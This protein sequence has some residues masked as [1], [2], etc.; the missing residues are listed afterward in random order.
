[1]QLSAVHHGQTVTSGA[2]PARG[3][4]LLAAVAGLQ[5]PLMTWVG[6][7]DEQ[8]HLPHILKSHSANKEVLRGHL[9]LYGR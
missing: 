9:Q 8:A 2:V 4:L 1:M 5:G 3:A 7:G 6:T